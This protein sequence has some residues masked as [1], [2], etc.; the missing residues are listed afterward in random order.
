MSSHRTLRFVPLSLL[1]LGLGV[2]ARPA[3]A[4]PASR[5]RLER[6]LQ[7]RELAADPLRL[8]YAL[9]GVELDLDGPEIVVA[10][11]NSAPATQTRLL[12]SNASR[13]SSSQGGVRLERAYATKGQRPD[14]EPLGFGGVISYR[15]YGRDLVGARGLYGTVDGEPYQTLTAVRE[16]GPEPAREGLPAPTRVDLA[17]PMGP[18]G[19]LPGERSEPASGPAPASASETASEHEAEPRRGTTAAGSIGIDGALRGE[20]RLGERSDEVRALQARL[21]AHRRALGREELLET[22]TYDAATV[23]ALEELQ[24]DKNLS[25][26]DARDPAVAAALAGTPDYASEPSARGPEV[27]AL[28]ARLNA[29]RAAAGLP[30]IDS[31]GILGGGTRDALRA[32]QRDAG[33]PE[34]GVADA[35]TDAALSLPPSFAGLARGDDGAR[36]TALQAQIND[37]RR[38][39]GIAPI[40]ED[41]DFGPGTEGGL[42]E[43]QAS[44]GLPQTGALDSATLAVLDRRPLPV[45]PLALGDEGPRVEAYQRDLNAHRVA[46]GLNPIETDGDFGGGTE[47][48]TRDLQRQLG[49]PETG[50]AD[51]PT[52]SAADAE[53]GLLRHPAMQAS[54]SDLEVLARIV[55]GECPETM[56]WEGKVA[57]AAVVLNRVRSAAF[58]RTIPG[59]AHQPSQFSC[60]NSNFRRKLYQGTIPDYAWR[61]AR[62]ALAGQDPS[63]GST[64][65][66]NPYLVAPSW[67]RS[68]VFVR[69]IGREGSR[70][71]RTQTTHDFYRER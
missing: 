15:I 20:L 27:A 55:K 1:I 18:I 6:L 16:L 68:K 71:L 25:S 43:L 47:S 60:Y 4:D 49:L 22:G 34:T 14:G 37:H 53:P 11:T 52:L 31:D 5:A 64:Y 51:P 46:W 2:W 26:S 57:V 67:S 62:A 24:R 40:A 63:L 3:L 21:N 69:R 36:V 12:L 38:A 58:P 30:P 59:V 32:F 7:D 44:H 23:A 61:A 8:L 66:F 39:A 10:L 65:Y 48:A 42:R 41:G 19:R 29:H 56:P 50:L 28:Q 54:A 33:I 35:A 17:R 45:E 9:G 13:L 70:A